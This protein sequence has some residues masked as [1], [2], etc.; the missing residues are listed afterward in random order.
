M[1]L[2]LAAGV[3][4]GCS[5]ATTGVPDPNSEGVPTPAATGDGDEVPMSDLGELS[6]SPVKYLDCDFS[7]HAPD[8]L[9]SVWQVKSAAGHGSAFYVGDGRWLTAEHVVSGSQSV[10]LHHSGNTIAAT[11]AASDAVADVAI[12]VT[13]SAPEALEFGALDEVGPGHQSYAVGFPLYDAPVA[14]I[15][16]GIIS[17]LETY[18]D[19][20]LVVVTDAA[21]NPGN[22]GGPLLNEC[23]QVIG[24]NIAA[25][26]DA[27]GLNYA[28]AETTLRH[29]LGGTAS[30]AGSA[31][32]SPPPVTT[33]APAAPRVPSPRV[34]AVPI[35]V[36]DPDGAYTALMVESVTS[37]RQI[38]LLGSR[39][40]NFDM[41]ISATFDPPVADIPAVP[42][43][44]PT[45]MLLYV[46][47]PNP[48][49]QILDAEA[50]TVPTS[51]LVFVSSTTVGD[52]RSL[53]QQFWA[54]QVLRAATRINGH[55]YLAAFQTRESSPDLPDCPLAAPSGTAGF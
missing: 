34:G 40:D 19:A 15:S 16:R 28:V 1:W 24:M 3:C 48:V 2:L 32:T 25:R 22:S 46:E 9:E 26:E 47:G 20:G 38:L 31:T 4:V 8:V 29:H 36:V 11:V 23:G 13:S 7:D 53:L 14:S 27:V 5:R 37:G 33:V 21:I 17:R 10:G 51:T 6:A 49:S 50:T 30:G 43:G 52:V 45:S 55:D 54:G 35:P 44:T 39:C 42:N 12:L 41:F 18:S